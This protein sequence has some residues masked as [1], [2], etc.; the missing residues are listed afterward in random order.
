MGSCTREFS[1]LNPFAKGKSGKKLGA[2]ASYLDEICA[3][4]EPFLDLKH[5]CGKA[6][7]QPMSPQQ[8][9]FLEKKYAVSK[10]LGNRAFQILVDLCMVG[11]CKKN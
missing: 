10:N 4:I 1:C 8:E 2:T 9:A 3:M 7:A 11:Q 6:R 5:N